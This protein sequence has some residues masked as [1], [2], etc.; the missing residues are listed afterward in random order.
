MDP[1]GWGEILF[2]IAV[3]VALAFPL[4]AY[5]ARVWQGESTWLDPVLKPVEGRALLD[6]SASIRRRART[7]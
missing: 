2:T 7:G 3:T 6:A 4:G 5:M 1:R